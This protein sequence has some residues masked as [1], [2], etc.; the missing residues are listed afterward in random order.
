MSVS[1]AHV[2]E[3]SAAGDVERYARIHV[4]RPPVE[5]AVMFLEVK[6]SASLVFLLP[7]AQQIL[8]LSQYQ[9][10]WYAARH[11]ELLLAGEVKSAVVVPFKDH[12]RTREAGISI[13][14]MI[15]QGRV[16]FWTWFW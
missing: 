14:V 4:A 10:R 8:I 16:V 3:W 9:S 6:A 11:Y 7:N 15:R 1:G 5:P 13:C 12:L 2:R